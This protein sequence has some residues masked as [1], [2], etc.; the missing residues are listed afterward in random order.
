MKSN[1]IIIFGTGQI[2]E[3]V[4]N[5]FEKDSEYKVVGFTVD[6]HFLKKKYFMK[7]P[8]VPF[9]EIKSKFSPK[10]FKIFIAVGYTDMNQLRYNK[11]I[12]AKKKG[13]HFASYV[14]SK[15]SI[16]GEQKI[17]ENCMIL[18]NTTI[19]TTA[20]IGNNVFIWS[21]NLIGH[22]VKVKDNTYIA[23]NCVIAG[24]SILGNFSFMGINST[25]SHGVKIGKNCF[26]GA[27]T[28]INKSI[29]ANSVSVSENSKIF[30]LKNL[31]LLKKLVK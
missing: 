31:N 14:S 12:E 21:N 3:E 29:S 10:F 28:F 7:K 22:H 2:A 23:G 16:I 26:I 17:K 24:S 9:S 6:S 15:A 4:H 18:E 11:Y 13:Y 25:I 8:V 5:Y 19:Q 30:K 1:K 27:N 20:S